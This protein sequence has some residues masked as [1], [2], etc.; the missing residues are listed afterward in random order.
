MTVLEQTTYISI[1]APPDPTTYPDLPTPDYPAPVPTPMPDS[2]SP[3]PMPDPQ[4]EPTPSPVPDMPPEITPGV[5]S[6]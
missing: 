6:I 5:P 3:Y 1:I 2:P 4:P